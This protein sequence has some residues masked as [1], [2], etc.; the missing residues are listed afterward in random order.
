MFTLDEAILKQFGSVWTMIFT[1]IC[2]IGALLIVSYIFKWIVFKLYVKCSNQTVQNAVVNI[3]YELDKLADNMSNKE[4]RNEAIRTVKDLFIWRAIPIPG[5][6]IGII[7]D[8]EV[9]AIRK[10]QKDTANNK[11]PYLHK[12]E[13][14]KKD[15]EQGAAK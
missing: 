6:V 1:L 3:I 12:D 11:D 14:V 13:D 15:D 9:A 2:I 10:I 4:K 5:F 7:I 8:A